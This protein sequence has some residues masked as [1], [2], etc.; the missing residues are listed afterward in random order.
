M[1]IASFPAFEAFHTLV[2]GLEK[3]QQEEV[4]VMENDEDDEPFSVRGGKFLLSLPNE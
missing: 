2:R 4:E 3:E 1:G